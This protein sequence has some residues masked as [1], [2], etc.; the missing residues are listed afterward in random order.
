MLPNTVKIIKFSRTVLRATSCR[1]AKT[2]RC[3]N[4]LA[5]KKDDNHALSS[6]KCPEFMRATK[7][8]HER[9]DYSHRAAQINMAKCAAGMHEMRRFLEHSN[10]VVL[11]IQEPYARHDISWPD[12]RTFYGARNAE[13]LWTFYGGS[14]FGTQCSAEC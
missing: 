9:V 6:S 4:C 11:M 7:I 1:T 5:F 2:P 3:A 14:W 10:I 13:E 12:C 8:A